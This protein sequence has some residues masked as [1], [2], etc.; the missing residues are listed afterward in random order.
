MSTGFLNNAHRVSS[1]RKKER[2]TER[3]R[4]K[5][6]MA[7]HRRQNEEKKYQAEISGVKQL[8]KCVGTLVPHA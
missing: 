7:Y 4:E 1:E 6:E 5:Y 2:D 8:E 3:E